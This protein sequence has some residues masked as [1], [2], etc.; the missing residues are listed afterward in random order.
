M[1]PFLLENKAILI[2]GL[3]EIGV[4]VAT[5]CA[6]IGAKLVLVHNDEE[7]LKS[8]VAQLPGTGHIQIVGDLANIEALDEIV[9]ALPVLDGW[10]NNLSMSTT[11]LTK[12]VNSSIIQQMENV[13]V[14]VPVLLL[15]KLVK[16]KKLNN[17]AS[18]VFTSSVSGVYTVHY[19]DSLNALVH[20]AINGFA[21][22]AAL[23]LARQGVRINTLNMSVVECSDT[24]VDTILSEEE[25]N[26][27]RNYFPLKRFGSPQDVA[28]AA[29]FFLSDASS[30]LTDVH[31]PVDGGYTLL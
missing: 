23:D 19:A 1:N 28:N 5:H 20:G 2:T 7:R 25:L 11:M 24:F 26:E 18:V 22:G 12:F 6:S 9:N 13:N 14:H 21:K 3:D 30:W 8:V 15:Q 29:A 31:L 4:T 16:R 10:S 27:K 17:P